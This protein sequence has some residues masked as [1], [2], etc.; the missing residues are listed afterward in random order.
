MSTHFDK[1][2]LDVQSTLLM[3]KDA[4]QRVNTKL[5]ELETLAKR[6]ALDLECVLL[7]RDNGWDHAH[8]TLQAYRDLMNHWYPQETTKIELPPLPERFNYTNS[9]ALWCYSR[10]TMVRDDLG[11]YVRAEDYDAL[12]SA[13]EALLAE[14]ERLEKAL[15]DI[16][17]T[18][19]KE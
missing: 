10:Y 8:K 12:R 14:V 4:Y 6:L 2:E 9:S 5:D 19:C 7:N 18:W 13:S 11:A 1:P 15:K 16:Q 17:K 3:W